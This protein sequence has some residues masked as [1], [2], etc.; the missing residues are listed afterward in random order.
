MLSGSKTNIINHMR[1]HR[2][3]LVAL[4]QKTEN[5]LF[6]SSMDGIILDA[7]TMAIQMMGYKE[8]ELINRDF[9]FL[10]RTEL[11]QQEIENGLSI[12]FA[13]PARL[14]MLIYL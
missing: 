11:T 9:S 13:G 12:W 4:S 14:F 5:A 8:E 6:I 10:R 1:L 3:V 7:N 2:D